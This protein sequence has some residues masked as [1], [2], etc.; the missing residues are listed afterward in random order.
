LEVVVVVLLFQVLELI[1][2]EETVAPPV[3]VEVVVVM[4]AL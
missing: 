3:T 1:P 4:T 2:M